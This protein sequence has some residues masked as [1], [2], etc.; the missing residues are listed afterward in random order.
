MQHVLLFQDLNS[1]GLTLDFK[2]LGK[3][4]YTPLVLPAIVVL[5]KLYK[6]YKHRHDTHMNIS[7]LIGKFMDYLDQVNVTSYLEKAIWCVCLYMMFSLV[8]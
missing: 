5:Y 8:V 7:Q 2:N 6:A 1:L 3:L 4:K